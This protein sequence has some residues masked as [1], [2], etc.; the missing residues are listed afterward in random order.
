MP[1]TVHRGRRIL[2]RDLLIF[3]LKLVLDA[4]KDVLLIKLSI[5]AALFDVLFGRRG[6]PL[7]FYGVLRLSE[8]FDLWLNLYGPAMDAEQM[9]DGLFGASEAG[10]DSLVGQLEEL[11][12][13]RAREFRAAE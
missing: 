12:Q 1:P 8:R 5:F 11:V 7:L 9:A 6:R 4:L 13:R 10:S 3:Q 2:I